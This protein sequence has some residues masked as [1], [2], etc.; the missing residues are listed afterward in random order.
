[1]KSDKNG[2]MFILKGMLLFGVITELVR[3]GIM[4]F[5]SVPRQT[6]LQVMD[7]WWIW[8]PLNYVS[9]SN[10]LAG[11]MADSVATGIG[12]VLAVIL[13]ADAKELFPGSL[14]KASIGMICG[15][16]V[17]SMLFPE[18]TLMQM[19]LLAGLVSFIFG[20]ALSSG[21]ISHVELFGSFGI[22]FGMILRMLFPYGGVITLV[23]MMALII[24][25]ITCLTGGF[26]MG[27]AVRCVCI[28]KP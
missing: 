15:A 7:G 13:F 8:N 5:L 3:D 28:R 21:K 14:R 23:A 16:T 25:N 2:G 10:G 22:I 6:A 1:M 18:A 9:W 27:C 11:F 24:T 4:M 20:A 12:L 19:V 17:T 26:V